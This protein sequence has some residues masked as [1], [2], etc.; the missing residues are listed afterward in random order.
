MHDLRRHADDCTARHEVAVEYGAGFWDDPR[1]A[2]DYAEGE[3]ESFFY[4]G[5]LE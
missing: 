1:E 2:S 3:A 4:T 5:G